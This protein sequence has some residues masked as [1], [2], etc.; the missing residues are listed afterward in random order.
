EEKCNLGCCKPCCHEQGIRRSR[1]LRKLLK[2]YRKRRR[3][4]TILVGLIAHGDLHT[5]DRKKLFDWFRKRLDKA[6]F[7]GFLVAGGLEVAWQ[8]KLNGWV[9]HFHLLSLGARKK[10]R[11]ALRASFASSDLKRPFV[12]QSLRDPRRQ[13][14]YLL[15]INTYYRPF[16]QIGQEKGPAYPLPRPQMEELLSWYANF[17]PS[18]FLFL[19]GLRRQGD[20]IRPTPKRRSAKR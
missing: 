2:R 19:Y 3:I 5:I 9:V 14:S 8:P 18:D 10:H 16:A 13:I 1:A 20:R 4:I 17:K 12:C 11:D 6:G 7:S 15:K